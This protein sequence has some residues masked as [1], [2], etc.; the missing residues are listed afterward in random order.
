MGSVLWP[1]PITFAIYKAGFALTN[2]LMS[3]SKLG[4]IEDPSRWWHW[5][6][7]AILFCGC[8]VVMQALSRNASE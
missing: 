6:V 3:A 7:F 8:E 2:G 5:L 1:V 4:T